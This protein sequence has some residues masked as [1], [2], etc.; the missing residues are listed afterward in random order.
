MQVPAPLE[1]ERATSAADA[2]RLLERLGG[3]ARIIAGGHS[4]LPMMKLRLANPEYL[5][6]INDLHGELGYVRR[7]GQQ[8]R[9]GA[10][11]RHRELLE[12]DELH[13]HFPIFRDAERVIADPPVRNR[14][15][16]GGALCQADPAEDL[17]SVC[18][19]LNASCVIRDSRGDRVV[20]ME[21][22]YR[23]PYETAVGQAEMLIEVRLPIRPGGSNA[24]AKV[25]L[26]SG[27]W[28][29]TAAGAALWL[30][31]HGRIADARV[32]LAAVGPSTTGIPE[33]SA[34]LRGSE[35]DAGAFDI[36]GRIAAESC[37]P[38]TDSRGSAAYKRHLAAELTRRTLATARD[39]ILARAEGRA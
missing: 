31:R 25:D 39:R 8:V 21:Q 33:I 6:D 27:A 30:D 36:A 3:E 29:V 26:R 2:I 14:G 1:Y 20:P 16:L 10:M 22:F 24:Y 11:T 5:V 19:T 28:A 13:E 35:P 7:V 15:T 38:V 9:I 4:L 23:G 18:T 12:S 34:A 32:G 37:Q 17:L